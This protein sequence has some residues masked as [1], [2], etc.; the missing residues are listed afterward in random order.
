M[1][2]VAHSG[3]PL[4]LRELW[5]AWNMD[6]SLLIPLA[7]AAFVYVCGIRNV[8][9]RAGR[10]H[11]IAVRSSLSF[12][13]ASLA[14][15]VALVS[16]LDALSGVLF[17]AH[18]VQH[19]ILILVVAPLL[20]MSDFP[21]ALLWALPRRWTH[22][23]AR[24][25]YHSQIIS[26]G[27]QV[28]S[29]PIFAW[30]LFTITLWVWHAPLLFES[31]LR[32]ERV[33]ALEH[34]GF[35]LA[36]MLFWWVLFNHARPNYVHYG[37]AIP[38]LFTT[39]LQSTVLGAL[40]TFTSQP[41]YPYYANLANPWGLTP[42]QDQQLAGIIMWLPGGA[43]FSVLTIGYFAAWLGALEQRSIGAQQRDYL[44]TRQ[45]H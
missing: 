29:N 30:L 43:V 38:Y 26:R 34:L 16:P 39:S 8:W 5:M 10:G 17:S 27:W 1:G 20:V 37:I 25:L 18:M 9:R 33:H 35:L 7:V 3:G 32:D 14:L 21:L 4:A 41:W 24:R 28:V 45:E 6:T 15:V 22:V 12:L 11:G 19:L 23:F 31:A 44:R 42:L 40:M 13:G 36:A 2:G